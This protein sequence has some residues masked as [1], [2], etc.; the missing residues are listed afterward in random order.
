MISTLNN[1]RIIAVRE[2]LNILF[3]RKWTILLT[4]T[5]VVSATAFLV[6]YLISPTYQASSVL[7]ISP[8]DVVLPVVEGVPASDFEKL[9]TFHTQKDIMR[10]IQVASQVVDKLDLEHLRVISRIEHMKLGVRAVK[11]QLGH[12]LA[13]KKWQS[14]EDYRA[15]SIDAVIKG[16]ELEGRPESQAIKLTYRAKNPQEA[17]DTLNA[18]ISTYKTYYLERLKDRAAG[19]IT[20]LDSQLLNVEKHLS[21]SEQNLL[22][23]KRSDRIEL[24]IPHSISSNSN[25]EPNEKNGADIITSRVQTQH[26]T[27]EVSPDS[28]GASMLGITGSPI[29][30]NELKLYVLSMEDER[31]KLLAEY[32]PNDPRV[33][34]LKRKISAY[35]KVLNALP[36]RELTLTRLLRE[37]E[38]SQDTAVRLRKNLSK[39]KVILSA[40]TRAINVITVIDNA[41][42][43]DDPVSPKSRLAMAIAIVF[44]LFFGFVLALLRHTLDHTIRS[45]RDL[46]DHLG[47]KPLGS[48]RSMDQLLITTKNGSKK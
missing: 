11:R 26:N 4:F 43:N 45:S 24:N 44:G 41:S 16:L 6:F 46:E 30:Q 42:V 14:P 38:M 13:I 17:A 22:T 9:S 23:F 32:T 5:G 28:T 36:E 10:S 18:I 39:A 3:L 25:I 2:T 33:S 35:T 12:W 34:E 37:Y 15:R 1:Q 19:M 7:V 21:S 20:Y 31:R 27:G 8:Q 29:V 48:L 40:D 47:L